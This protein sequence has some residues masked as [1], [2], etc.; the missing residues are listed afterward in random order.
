MVINIDCRGVQQG[1]QSNSK[2]FTFKRPKSLEVMPLKNMAA[3]M[4]RRSIL[5]ERGSENYA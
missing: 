1:A 4:Q 3:R 5:N 2:V